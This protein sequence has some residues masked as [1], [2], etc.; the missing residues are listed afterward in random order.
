MYVIAFMAFSSSLFWFF[1]TWA[2]AVWFGIIVLV[3]FWIMLLPT[4]RI[5]FAPRYMTCDKQIVYYRNVYKLELD[6]Q[7]GSLSISYADGQNLTIKR[8][9]FSTKARKSDKVAANKKAKFEKFAQSLAK[10]VKYFAPQA[11]LIGIPQDE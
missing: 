7:E 4:P 3:V 10:H 8:D 6:D 11:Q 1:G 9:N 2:F 5:T